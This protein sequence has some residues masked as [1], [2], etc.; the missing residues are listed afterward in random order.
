MK[1]FIQKIFT[2]LVF[3]VKTYWKK[4][5]L[6]LIAMFLIFYLFYD[7][8]IVHHVELGKRWSFV[9]DPT[10]TVF[11]LL[12]PIILGFLL[13]YNEWENSLENKLIVHYSIKKEGIK[14]YVTSCYNVNLLHGSDMRAIGQ[15]IGQQMCGTQYLKFNPSIKPNS[16]G[17]V[18]I[19]NA[20][21]KTQWIKYFEIEFLLDSEPTEQFEAKNSYLVWNLFN[22]EKLIKEIKE[23]LDS[24]FHNNYKDHIKVEELLSSNIQSKEI[25]NSILK[26]MDLS[27]QN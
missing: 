6:W 18:K 16:E 21:N 12:I 17:I 4:A 14:K 7:R 3:I 8:F 20:K 27:H 19:K 25:F 26:D 2:L 15:Q 10:F 5:I 23:R 1:D 22:E 11:S 13:L 9:I 24:T